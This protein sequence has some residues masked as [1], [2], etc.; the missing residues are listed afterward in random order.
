MRLTYS[1]RRLVG[2]LAVVAALAASTGLAVAAAAPSAPADR[3]AP[4]ANKTASAGPGD[5]VSAEPFTA[6]ADPGKVTT[7]PAKAWKVHY[8][9]TSA[10]GG[11]IEVSGALLVPTAA[12]DGDGPRPVI[13]YSVGTHGMGDQCAPSNYL[14]DGRENEAG[15]MRTLLQSGWAVAVTDYQ[16]LGTPGTH[17]YAV[18]R[19]E[20]HAVLDMVRAATKVDGAG[21]ATD[22]PVGLW[23]YSQGGQ[24]TAWGAQLAASYA[25]ELRVKGAAPGGVPADLPRIRDFVDGGPFSGLVLMA[26]VGYDAAYPELNLDSYLTAAGKAAVADIKDDCVAEAT[27]KYAFRRIADYTTTDPTRT[28]A[29]KARFN[30]NRLGGAAKPSAPVYLYHGLADELVPYDQAAQLRKEWCGNGADVEWTTYPGEHVTAYIEAVPLAV[31]WMRGRFA[32]QDAP[33]NCSLP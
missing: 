33:N 28:E 32:G 5:V 27:S 30:A 7:L 3:S 20:G 31:E 8:R 22:A 2:S 4:G 23:G 12:W 24:S 11:A 29:W 17:T 1:T 10:T 21:L 25:P 6:Y 9:S 14:A 13:G 18:G 15:V 19:A 16:N 26:G